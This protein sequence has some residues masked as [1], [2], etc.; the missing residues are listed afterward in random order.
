MSLLELGQYLGVFVDMLTADSKYLV[1]YCGNWRFLIEMQFSEKRKTFL[2]F[3][4]HLWN[5]HET[6]S[7][8]K[9]KDDGHS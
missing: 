6:S 3:L 7:I 9:K 2:Y 4:S 5:L 8:L 1:Q